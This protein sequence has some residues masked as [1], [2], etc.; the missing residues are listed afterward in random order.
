MKK[1]QAATEMAIFAT[2]ILIAISFLLSYIQRI[3]D[4]QY[5]IMETFRRALWKANHNNASVSY[6]CIE[7]RRQADL[8][9]PL[10]GSRSQESASSSV[11]WAVPKVGEE[12]NSLAFYKINEDEIQ[13]QPENFKFE[14]ID[15]ISETVSTEKFTKT[16][17]PSQII[18]RR[19]LKLKDTITFIFKD[20]NGNEVMRITQGLDEDGKYRSSAYS[21]EIEKERIWK[22]S[23]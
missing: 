19:Y 1:A 6:S 22:T 17:T 10:K 8:F 2:L 3:E 9:A 23:F 20:K 12:P 18:T 11:F 15:T 14:D 16:Q 4:R 21:K 7:T 5:L 13:Y